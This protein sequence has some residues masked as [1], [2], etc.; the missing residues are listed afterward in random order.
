MTDRPIIF[1]GPMV[2]AL[3]EG[4]KTQTRRLAW[5]DRNPSTSNRIQ[6]SKRWDGSTMWQRVK[7]GDRLWVR[8]SFS[9][10]N[11]QVVIY[12]ANWRED[13]LARR[14]DNVPATDAD[15]RWR[16]SIHMPRWASRITL[17]VTETRIERLED[18]SWDDAI[19]EGVV[20]TGRRDG[21][22][23]PHCVVPYIH[24]L[25]EAEAQAVFLSLWERLH[26]VGST[27]ANPEVCVI[28]FS[29]EK[30]N[31]DQ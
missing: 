12:R 13:A 5:S 9:A 14:L 29:V 30:R 2:C 27:N 23:W 17:T 21:E 3:I 24:G 8:E 22:P 20:D 4:R 16:P 10:P 6:Y 25:Q 15:I 19:A 28:S 31:I 1:S 11:D 26:G 18:I 7:P